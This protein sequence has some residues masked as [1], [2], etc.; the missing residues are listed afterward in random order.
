MHTSERLPR[1]LEDVR[2]TIYDDEREVNINYVSTYGLQRQTHNGKLSSNEVSKS[3]SLHNE[4]TII[5]DKTTQTRTFLCACKLIHTDSST[6]IDIAIASSVWVR[7]AKR[8]D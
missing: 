6:C 1:C 7:N 3:S 5:N 8:E 2:L 4:H